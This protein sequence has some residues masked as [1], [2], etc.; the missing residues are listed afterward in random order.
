MRTCARAVSP[1]SVCTY[2]ARVKYTQTR[3][4]SVFHF[5]GGGARVFSP[6]PFAMKKPPPSRPRSESFEQYNGWGPFYRQILRA[7]ISAPPQKTLLPIA[8]R[9]VRFRRPV[10]HVQGGT[11]REKTFGQQAGLVLARRR[12]QQA[13][14]SGRSAARRAAPAM[15]REGGVGIRPPSE[16]ASSDFQTVK[17]AVRRLEARI[18]HG[19]THLF[20][21]SR[22][23]GRVGRPRGGQRL[24]CEG[25]AASESGRHLSVRAPISKRKVGLYRGRERASCTVRRTST[26]AA[27]VGAGSIV[28]AAGGACGGGGGRRQNL[29]AI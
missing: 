14:R 28:G 27:G 20:G 13:P 17:W 24:R 12:S 1:A 21:R 9:T 19:A 15:P 8:R 26:R 18:M 4:P 29:L 2:Y 3:L 16:R 5:F 23:R 7:H 10:L 11:R 25:G 6:P 22:P